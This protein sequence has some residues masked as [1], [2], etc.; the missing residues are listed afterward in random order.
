MSEINIIIPENIIKED[1]YYRVQ[2]YATKFQ[3]AK[4]GKQEE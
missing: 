1:C 2:K 4:F 3:V